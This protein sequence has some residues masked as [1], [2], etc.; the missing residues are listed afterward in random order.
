MLRARQKIEERGSEFW[1]K[2]C[3]KKFMSGVRLLQHCWEVHR[4]Q[5]GD[6]D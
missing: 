2:I 5:L 6:Y 4:D 3:R 1:C